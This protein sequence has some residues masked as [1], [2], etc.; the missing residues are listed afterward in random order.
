MEAET[1]F[2]SSAYRRSRTAYIL[3]AMFEYFVSIL[4]TDAFLAKLLSNVGFR[5][6]E[7]GI[8]SSFISLAFVFQVF[9][10]LLV[11]KRGSKKTLIVVLTMVGQM[12]FLALYVLP[13]SGM[14]PQVRQVL[15]YVFIIGAYMS[16]Y[17]VS[18]FLFQWANSYVDPYRR[19]SYSANMQIISLIGGIAFSLSMGAV[20]NWFE[21]TNNLMGGFFFLAAVIL[22]SNLAVF[23]SLML[24]KREKIENKESIPRKKFSDVLTNTFGNPNF[25]RLVVISILWKAAQY[26]TVGFMGTFKT[27]TL[28][29]GLALS[30][31]AV[32]AIAMVGSIVQLL[33]SRPF[34]KYSDRHSF[35]SGFYLSM[36]FA[37]A[38]FL[39]NVF[40]TRETWFLVIGYTVLFAAGAAG[41]S[42]N[43]E[44]MIY[45]YVNS[46]YIAEALALQNC[47]SGVC[48]FLCSLLAGMLLDAIQKAGNTFLGIPL[49]GQQLL[50][51]ISAAICVLCVVYMRLTIMKEKVIKQ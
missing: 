3:Y 49:F 29:N 6:S 9:S 40:T 5:D 43:A 38:A 21:E 15:V 31:L 10:L 30:V 22:V 28:G 35:A 48:G 34:G 27:D 8:L 47:I 11:K 33:M 26:F 17:L 14:D 23:L 32:Q 50:G 7:I 45:S 25:R 51:L 2:S 37:I 4:L 1:D 42:K 13:F 36:F 16:K 18:T 46:N 39:C 12:L 19:A 44:N 41:N 24:I 20:F